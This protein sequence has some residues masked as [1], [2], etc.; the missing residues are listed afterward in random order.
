M[1]SN[2]DHQQDEIEHRQ[3]LFIDL[4]VRLQAAELRL[5]SQDPT[6]NTG[7]SGSLSG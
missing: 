1:I 5:Q 4:R 2:N 6:S 7:H 3:N